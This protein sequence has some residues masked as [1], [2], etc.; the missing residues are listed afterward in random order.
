MAAGGHLLNSGAFIIDK[1]LLRSAFKESGTYAAMMGIVSGAALFL[2][3]F[4][5]VWPTNGMLLFVMAVFGAAFILGLWA[6]FEA[7]RDGEA[8]RVVPVV[9]SMTPVFTL[10]GTMLCLGERLTSRQF[11]GFCLLWIATAL[12]TGSGTAH[13]RLRSRTVFFALVS[14]LCFAITS[15]AGKQVFDQAD[16]ISVIVLSRVVCV[17]C[18]LMIIAFQPH[19][20]KEMSALLHLSH[21]DD[22]RPM[23]KKTL[24]LTTIGQGS[25]VFGFIMIYLAM[26]EGSAA[27]INALQAVQY[28]AIALLGWFGTAAM[29]AALDE[30]AGRS[31]KIFKGIA[32]G[33]VAIGLGLI[34]S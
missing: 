17:I 25:G 34:T 16:F 27:L 33:I 4:V 6:F 31:T 20:R 18:G 2:S 15:V 8:S 9:G 26:R 29:R 19:V 1:M 30:E 11:F 3:P 14:A 10:I 22:Y 7:L 23:S 24:F 28:V 32:I 13:R 21:A 12:L 5:R